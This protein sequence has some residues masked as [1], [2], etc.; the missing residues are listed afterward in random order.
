MVWLGV[1]WNKQD[2]FVQLL[3]DL[4]HPAIAVSINGL[5]NVYMANSNRMFSMP[6][7]ASLKLNTEHAISDIQITCMPLWLYRAVATS[8]EAVRLIGGYVCKIFFEITVAIKKKIPP[9][10]TMTRIWKKQTITSYS[11]EWLLRKVNLVVKWRKKVFICVGNRLFSG[12]VETGQPDWWLRACYNINITINTLYMP[13]SNF[14]WS[15]RD[16]THGQVALLAIQGSRILSTLEIFLSTYY[17]RQ[18]N[19]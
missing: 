3:H 6:Q 7:Y 9:Q 4:I 16:Y 17:T 1:F 18:L 13:E 15:S 10:K 5:S 12:P 2:W 11:S 14:V 19:F 8:F